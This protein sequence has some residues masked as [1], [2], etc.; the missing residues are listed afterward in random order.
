M[1]RERAADVECGEVSLGKDEEAGVSEADLRQVLYDLKAVSPAELFPMCFLL[2]G[3]HH[4]RPQIIF[5]S[6]TNLVILW[7]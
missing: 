5:K 1:L 2:C 6:I 3:V 7:L 4:D